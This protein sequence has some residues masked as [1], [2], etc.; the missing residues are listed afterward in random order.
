MLLPPQNNLW[1]KKVTAPGFLLLASVPT[2]AEPAQNVDG[3]VEP[4]K[5]IL[6]NVQAVCDERVSFLYALYKSYLRFEQN[7]SQANLR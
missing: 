6:D 4:V 5:L 2:P 7:V 1:L 3:N